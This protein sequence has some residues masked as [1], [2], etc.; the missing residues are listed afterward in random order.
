[1]RYEL[2]D[3]CLNIRIDSLFNETI[4]DF[5]DTYIPSSKIQHLLIQNKWISI[6]E[7]PVKRED[8]IKGENLMINIYPYSNMYKKTDYKI[9]VI[10]EDEFIIVVNKPKD[11]WL[12]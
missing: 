11:I 4:Q 6:D 7:K 1:M 10:Y 5:F 12:K 3:R 8:L 2:A 9:D